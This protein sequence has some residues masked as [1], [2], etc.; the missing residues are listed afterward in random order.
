LSLLLQRTASRRDFI[1]FIAEDANNFLDIPAFRL[2]Y[3]RT[4]HSDMKTTIVRV[5]LQDETGD[6]FLVISVPSGS[7]V[8]QKKL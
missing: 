1:Q 2:L 4:E 7:S 3:D 5:R 6:D 8:T